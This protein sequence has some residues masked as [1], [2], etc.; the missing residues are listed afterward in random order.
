MGPA[1]TS[2]IYS[3]ANCAA[4]CYR[5]SYTGQGPLGHTRSITRTA[6]VDAARQFVD[7]AR[8]CASGKKAKRRSISRQGTEL[9]LEETEFEEGAD[10][11]GAQSRPD[12]QHGA[13]EG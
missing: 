5:R 4:S 2:E 12:S 11:G 13:L 6:A 9:H 3:C 8:A 10:D 7:Q 1:P